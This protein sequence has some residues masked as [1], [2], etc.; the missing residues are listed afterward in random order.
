MAETLRS[1]LDIDALT[2][3]AEELTLSEP[4]EGEEPNNE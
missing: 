3:A 1:T 4:E 2:G